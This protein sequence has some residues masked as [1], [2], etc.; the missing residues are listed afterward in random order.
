MKIGFRGAC[1]PSV[2]LIANEFID[3]YMPS[4]NGE[5]VKVYLYLLRHQG[6]EISTAGIADALELTEGDVRRALQRWEREGL[7]G[8]E[9]NVQGDAESH[10]ESAGCGWEKHPAV[11]VEQYSAEEEDKAEEISVTG[12]TR[13]TAER[14][15]RAF[16]KSGDVALPERAEQSPQPERQTEVVTRAE[17]VSKSETGT[18]AEAMTREASASR[19]SLSPQEESRGYADTVA[20][21]PD[22][23]GVD[24]QKLRKDEE[25]AGL[26]YIIQRYLSKIFSQTDS[27]TVAY[28][29]DVLRM[30][31]DLLVYLAEL[32]AQNQKTS[33]RYFESIALD[34]YRRGIRTVEQAKESG[35]RY[36]SEV[37]AVMKAFGMNG[38]DPG[39]EELKLIRK[40]FGQYGFTKEMVLLACGRT[41][42]R[43]QKPSFPYTDKILTEWKNAGIHTTAEANRLEEQHAARR[44]RSGGAG[45]TGAVKSAGTRFS[46]FEQRDDDID[47]LAMQLMKQKLGQ[48]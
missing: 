25:F 21:L 39:T 19:T 47:A 10:G 44:A 18:R 45:K 14:Q 37:Y 35:S 29:Y 41:L 30:P 33:L 15:H 43:I 46:N 7:I 9:E 4:A 3:H 34:W 24:F 5:Y 31:P 36:S 40:W 27:E 38:R 42:M 28:L 8:R 17:T 32:C 22:K 13:D 16:G 26:L 6:E 48:S 12:L 11:T 20:A 1:V 2:T 23:S